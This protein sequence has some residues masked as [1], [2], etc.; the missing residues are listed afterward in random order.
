M[1]RGIIVFGAS[2]AGTTTIAK[3][4]EKSLGFKCFDIDD[5]FWQWDTDVPYTVPRSRENA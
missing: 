4:I 5:Y 3:A 2:G 1:S